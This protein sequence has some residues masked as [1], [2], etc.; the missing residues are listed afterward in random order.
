MN[1]LSPERLLLLAV[2]AALAGLYVWVQ[3]RR[4]HAAVRYTNLAVLAEVAPPR[5]GWRRHVPA[6][7]VA[8]A[9]SAL[10]VAIAE[11]V[12]QVRVPKEAA[13][14]MMVID[15]SASMDATDVEP[16]RLE[17]ATAA[18]KTFVGDLPPQ[19]RVGLVSFDRIARVVAS[20]TVD[21]QAVLDGIDRLILGTGTATG[22]AIYTALDALAAANDTAGA[23]ATTSG[24]SAMVLLSDGVPTV[25]RPVLGAAQDAAER[26]VPISTIAFGT[27]SGTVTVQGR[28]VSVP[29]DPD[30]MASVAEITSGK[31]FK[32]VSAKELRSVYK[33]I[34]TRV[35]YETEQRDASGPPLTLAVIALLAASGLALL[36]NG[37][38]V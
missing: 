30:T 16:S 7:A 4:R 20:P 26:G 11:P 5:P 27:S 24:G 34:G 29:A 9:L 35:G 36:W 31:Y 17:A 18:A 14:V 22:E 32:A 15:V 19:V 1:F 8:V 12:H 10:V 23:A 21:H 6:A 37:R 33:D 2:V 28:L 3:R 38:L 13:T 25:G